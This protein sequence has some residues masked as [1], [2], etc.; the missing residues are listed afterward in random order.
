VIASTPAVS[1]RTSVGHLAG[2]SLTFVSPQASEWT[3]VTDVIVHD[4]RE[5]W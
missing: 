3:Q 5:R 2:E 4:M 1:L